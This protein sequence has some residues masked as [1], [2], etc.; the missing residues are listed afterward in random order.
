MQKSKMP[1]PLLLY[2]TSATTACYTARPL[3]GLG[4]LFSK[5]WR[6]TDLERGCLCKSLTPDYQKHHLQN[7]RLDLVEYTDY[8]A[9][10]GG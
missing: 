7:L 6:E 1:I 3:P 4:E 9:C 5:W 8:N 10:I 2:S